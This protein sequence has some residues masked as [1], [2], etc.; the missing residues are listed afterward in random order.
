MRARRNRPKVRSTAE[1][2]GGA[3]LSPAGRLCCATRRTRRAAQPRWRPQALACVPYTAQFAC[4]FAEIACGLTRS[5]SRWHVCAPAAVPGAPPPR[6]AQLRGREGPSKGNWIIVVTN[7]D[8]ELLKRIGFRQR[9]KR[10]RRLPNAQR[11]VN[12]V[13]AR[14]RMC[15]VCADGGTRI[16]GPLFMTA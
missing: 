1:R 11:S 7:A 15:T 4:D 14:A 2:F 9:G 10:S 3:P 6:S 12:V 13:G 5:S 8:N 16:A